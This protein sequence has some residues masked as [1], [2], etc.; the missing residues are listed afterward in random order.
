MSGTKIKKC[1][2]YLLNKLLFKCI[3]TVKMASHINLREE[4]VWFTTLLNLT[5]RIKGFFCHQKTL[6]SQ[7]IIW[8][9]YKFINNCFPYNFEQYCV[10][11][12]DVLANLLGTF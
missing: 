5:V 1:L 3:F 9:K 6:Q 11:S 12:N 4:Y 2:Y 8:D 7:L 10:L